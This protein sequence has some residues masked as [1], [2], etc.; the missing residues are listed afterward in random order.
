MSSESDHYV[1]ESATTPQDNEA[2]FKSKRMVYSVDSNSNGGFFGQEIQFD[3]GTLGSQ[4]DWT[5]LAEAQIAIPVFTTISSD[6]STFASSVTATFNKDLTVLKNGSHHLVHSTS[7]SING[8]TIQ[9]QQNFQ[10]ISTHAD[11]MTTFSQEELNKNA[12]TLHMSKMPEDFYGFDD[13]AETSI[14]TS[15]GA[16]TGDTLRNPSTLDR[17]NAQCCGAAG[18]AS[19]I[20]QSSGAGKSVVQVRGPATVTA[21]DITT[22]SYVYVKYDTITIRL[23]DIVPAVKSIPPLKNIK[24]YLYVKVNAIEAKLTTA[25]ASNGAVAAVGVVTVASVNSTAGSSCPVQIIQTSSTS[26]ALQPAQLYTITNTTNTIAAGA[27]TLRCGPLGVNPSS[28]LTTPQAAH[29]NAR[30]IAPKYEANPAVDAALSMKKQFTVWERRSSSA[31]LAPL[32]SNTFNINSGV[33]NPRFVRCYPYFEGKGT[34]S[35]TNLPAGYNPFMSVVS[36]EIAGTSPLAQLTNFNVYVGNKAVFQD[37]QSFDYENF[38]YEVARL[39][40]QGGLDSQ[41]SSGLINSYLWE[42][43][44]RYYCA[45]VSRRLDSE[46]GNLKSIQ[47]QATNSTKCAMNILVDIFSERVYTI[48]TALCQFI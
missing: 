1:V 33:P 19:V 43:F 13:T 18:L 12:S 45:D 46:D 9:D 15:A 3:L 38:C 40:M 6:N 31:K 26:S 39:G 14:F 10:N 35:I 7:L 29:V 36:S 37:G 32:Q 44:Y 25:S 22:G 41:L 16:V 11:M 42:R 23:K 2:L 47:V 21:G 27:W 20:G 17:K 30:L 28:T 24:G 8:R 34:S 4:G 5:Y 48:D